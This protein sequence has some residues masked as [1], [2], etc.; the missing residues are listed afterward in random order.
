MVRYTGS[1]GRVEYIQVER[2]VDRVIEAEFRFLGQGGGWMDANPESLCLLRSNGILGPDSYLNQIYV[3][4]RFH[5]A[6]E[7]AGVGERITLEVR[8]QVRV[9]V[10]LD[11]GQLIIARGCC[12]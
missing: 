2:N 11:D 9:R 10:E 7:R 8:I 1:K 12:F 4:K 3:I 6:R 5:D